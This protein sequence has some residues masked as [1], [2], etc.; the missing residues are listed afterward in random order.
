M[1]DLEITKLCAEAMGID[2]SKGYATIHCEECDEY[3]ISY[4]NGFKSQVEASGLSVIASETFTN[5]DTDYRTQ[6]TKLVAAKSDVI[7]IIALD[8]SLVA[9]IKQAR[10]MN[11]KTILMTNWV[12]SNS[13]VRDLAGPLA[14]GVY[15]TTPSFN[16]ENPDPVVIQFRT[17]YQKVYGKAPSAY[18][19]I[20]YDIVN[21]LGKVKKTSS[22]TGLDIIEK[23][24]DLGSLKSVMGDLTI[25]SNKEITFKLFPAKI[26]NG[27]VVTFELK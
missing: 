22:D 25:D 6:L 14:E 4:F 19:A 12:L 27:K 23:I 21:I 11:I 20:A 9:I 15:F 8:K 18:A 5:K 3:G 24:K 13:S 26:E 17:D 1:T 10:E 16:L 7:Y 2:F